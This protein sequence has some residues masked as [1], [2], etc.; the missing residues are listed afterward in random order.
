MTYYGASVIHLKTIKPL[1]RKHIPLY[2][3]SFIDP[4]LPGTR[5]SDD[6]PA[7]Y[8]PMVAVERNQAYLQVSTRDYAFVAEQ[9][10]SDLFQRIAALRLQVNLMQNS[11][12]SFKLC[13]NDTD[14]R[15]DRLISQIEAAYEVSVER[16]LELITIRHDRP[17]V[18]RQLTEGKTV[19]FEK[20]IPETLQLICRKT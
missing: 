8:P 13:V 15:V 20:R 19:V 7:A 1:Q 6:V 10:L 17:E 14:D 9:H 4:E 12:I 16:G 5:I 11:A 18:V 2:V 3:K